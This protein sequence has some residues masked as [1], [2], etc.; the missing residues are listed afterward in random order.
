M[1]CAS[2]R[3]QSDAFLEAQGGQMGG[4]QTRLPLKGAGVR[5]LGAISA[6]T[7]GRP[8][9]RIR[10]YRSGRCAPASAVAVLLWTV[11]C[12]WRG[13]KDAGE[14]VR[15]RG[16]LRRLE[17]EAAGR[18]VPA[19]P[20]SPRPAYVF[21]HLHKTGG[22]NLKKA[23]FGFAKRNGLRLYH[24]CRPA[25]GESALTA[26]WFHRRKRADVDYDCNMDDFAALSH[27]R[28][29]SYDMVVGHQFV[30]AHRLMPERDVRYFTFV[31]RPLARK[32]SHFE[33]FEASHLSGNATAAAHERNRRL[34]SYMAERNR[35][36]MVKRLSATSISSELATHVRSNLID[37]SSHAA[38]AALAQ[39]RA[40]LQTRFFFVGLLERYPESVC[41]LSSILNAACYAGHRGIDEVTGR[42]LNPAGIARGRANVR[43]LALQAVAD[44]P[45]AVRRKALAAEALDVSLYKLATVLFEQQ[46]SRYPDCRGG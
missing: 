8:A 33:H 39:A 21:L 7:A 46:L 5:R 43:G 16:G 19:A 1:H 23:L 11:A 34:W 20:A 38:Q 29:N 31:R 41:V 3:A 6:L 27:Q 28:R 36:Y 40:T 42:R 15:H 14:D 26:W 17:S 22:N 44:L 10:A 45:V 2:E 9:K 4:R 35:N 12:F 30:G 24:T 25:R 37:W 32:A 13:H 18:C